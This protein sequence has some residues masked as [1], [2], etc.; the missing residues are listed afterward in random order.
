MYFIKIYGSNTL[1]TPDSQG[2]ALGTTVLALTDL[3]TTS[4][5]CYGVYLDLEDESEE[6]S[7]GGAVIATISKFRKVYSIPIQEMDITDY[8]STL[9]NLKSLLLKRYWY[10]QS[11]NTVVGA[12]PYTINTSGYMQVIGSITKE[13]TESVGR[14]KS[15]TLKLKHRAL[16]NG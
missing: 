3:V 14:L 12:V 1:I 13:E 10:L 5:T 6:L 15:F 2:E 4:W 11:D 8:P 9:S 16:Y 7:G